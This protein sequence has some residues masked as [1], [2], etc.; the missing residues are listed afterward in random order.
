MSPP[1]LP[2]GPDRPLEPTPEEAEQ[3]LA[4]FRT[5]LR[6]LPF[7]HIPPHQTAAELREQRPFFWKCIMGVT[8]MSVIQLHMLKEDIRREA[9]HRVVFDN[10][11]SM[12]VLLG[13]VCYMTW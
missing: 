7:V 1:T 2:A 13:L 4:K 6:W 10:E 12:D 9:A 5:W 8:S 11:R 3:Y